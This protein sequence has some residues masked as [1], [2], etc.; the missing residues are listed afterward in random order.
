MLMSKEFPNGENVGARLYARLW[1]LM[2]LP[3]DVL[4]I[5]M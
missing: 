5:I 2:P 3:R 4:R 1:Q